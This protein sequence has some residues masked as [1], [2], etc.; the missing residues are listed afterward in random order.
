M[1]GN[2]KLSELE[3]KEEKKSL[4]RLFRSRCFVC[5][6]RF[7]KGFAYHHLW[8]DGGEPDYANKNE[9]WHYVLNRSTISSFSA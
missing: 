3:I 7:G 9:Y 2:G 6:K 8:Y 4:A 5:H 1:Q